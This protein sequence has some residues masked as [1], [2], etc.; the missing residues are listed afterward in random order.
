MEMR[1]R[2]RR[3]MVFG[4]MVV[5]LTACHDAADPTRPISSGSQQLASAAATGGQ[6]IPDQ[7]IVVFRGGVADVDNA[8]RGLASANGATIRFIYR[9][10]LR[11]F[12]AQMSAAAADAIARNPNVDFVEQD[13]VV[14]AIGTQTM[15]SNGDPWGL[16]RIDARSGLNNTYSYSLTGAGVYAY[17]ID[18]GIRTSHSEFE[19]RAAAGFTAINDGNGSND[20]NGHGTHVSGTVGGRTYG[21]AKAV[22]LVAVR[23]LNCSGSGTWDQVIAGIDWVTGHHVSP[24]V[25]NMSLGGGASSSVDRA[26]RNSIASGVSYA[27][28]AGNGNSGGVAQDACNYSPARVTEA[29]TI[30]ATTKTDAKASWSNYGSCVDWFAP[31]VGIKSAWKTSDDATNTISG[32]SMATPHT[33]GVA[34]LYLEAFPTSTPQQVRDALYS[35]TTKNIVT[36]SNTANA[37]LLYSP[38]TG[39]GSSGGGGPP[40][41]QAPTAAFTFSCTYLDCTF[42]DGS[43]DSDGSIASRSWTFGDGG[44]S[45]ETNPSHSFASAGSYTVELTVTDNDGATNSTSQSVTVSAPPGPPPGPPPPDNQAPVANFTY[46]CTDLVCTFTDASSDS[47]GNVASWSWNFG[48]GT[49]STASSPSHTFAAAGTYTVQLTVTDNAG[50]TN[51]TSQDVG[52]TAPPPGP[53]LSVTSSKTKGTWTTVLTWGDFPESV[54]QVNVFRNGVVAAIVNVSPST[55]SESGKGGGSISYRV[56]G[57]GT[58]ICTNTVT[59]NP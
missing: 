52:V 45:T 42:T 39:F 29:M 16:D 36:A 7:Y 25:A 41:N 1:G 12:S 2:M 34:A 4:A 14:E 53:V 13:Q 15:D 28:A 30:G 22:H 47:D 3:N 20:C 56:C 27:I 33:A 48:D 57:V 49:S 44:A 19:G 58:S 32:T 23:V 8:A 35:A 40:P 50:A 21:V 31:G 37:H 5:A 54:T 51:T 59:I 6:Q 46:S 24:A 11:G 38:S 26:V 43:T 55:W 18:T 10:A 17:I 9:Y